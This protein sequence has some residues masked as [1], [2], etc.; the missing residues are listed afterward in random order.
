MHG[1]VLVIDSDESNLCLNN[2]LG[3]SNANNTLMDYLGGKLLITDKLLNIVQK[4]E[5]NLNIFGDLSL[6]KLSFNYT[7]WSDN[8]GFIR[9]GKIEHSMEGCGCPMGAISRDFLKH[10]HISSDEWVLVDTEAGI[11]H[12]GRGVLEGVD[13]IISIV[14]PSEDAIFLANKAFDLS[15]ENDKKFG[16]IFNKVNKNTENL[17]KE[18]LN[19]NI[20]ILGKIAYY[21]NIS[22]LNLQGISLNSIKINEINEIIENIV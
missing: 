15:L 20:K 6:N 18:K 11:E 4:G 8:L 13:F 9:I 7:S 19:S 14:D 12:F 22:K 5:T 3:I 1:K 21:F 16:V 10:L 17:L 2:I